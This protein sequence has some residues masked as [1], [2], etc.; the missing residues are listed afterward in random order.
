[1][2]LKHTDINYKHPPP[3]PG[4]YR[5]HVCIQKY[6]PWICVHNSVFCSPVMAVTAVAEEFSKGATIRLLSD[7]LSFSS[8]SGSTESSR[9]L[10]DVPFLL[11]PSY[12]S[13]VFSVPSYL[14]PVYCIEGGFFF[15]SLFCPFVSPTSSPKHQSKSLSA[16]Q[17]F[18]LLVS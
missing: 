2:E 15:C 16:M 10:Y 4:G 13:P 11:F 9:H 8:H 6:R 3:L 17:K 18:S 12:T 7:M 1:M 14:V 5:V